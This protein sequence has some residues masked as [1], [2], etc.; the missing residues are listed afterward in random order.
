MINE[1]IKVAKE[2]FNRGL[3]TGS[4]GNISFRKDD[5]VYISKT[6]TSFRTLAENDFATINLRTGDISGKPSKEF[7]L[8]LALYKN[9]DDI[10]A[11]IHTHSFYSTLISCLKNQT[12]AISNLFSY[13]PYLKMKTKEKIISVSYNA[14]GSTDLFSDFE[15][16]VDKEVS[17]Y[18]LRNHGIVV[19]SKSI[20]D[21]FNII[22]E[23]EQSA[24]ISCY[25]Q[26]YNKEE[27][28]EI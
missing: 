20:V 18:I 22:E 2:L 12:K 9:N 28:S 25:I 8:H 16:S 15:K 24:K 4:T 14:P 6:N 27:Y 11:I 7:P 17:T 23:F 26:H 1:T 13:T 3:V 5:I 19:G 21:C 10:E